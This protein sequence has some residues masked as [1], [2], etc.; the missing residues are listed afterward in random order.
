MGISVGAMEYISFWLFNEVFH[1]QYT[2]NKNH[3]IRITNTIIAALLY[4]SFSKS[5]FAIINAGRAAFPVSF[6]RIFLVFSQVS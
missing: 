1:V 2:G 4:F 6:S 3:M 5:C